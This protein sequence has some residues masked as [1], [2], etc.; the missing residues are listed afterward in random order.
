MKVLVTGAHGF[1]GSHVCEHLLAQG[2][3]VR[4]LVS[5]WGEVTNL[6]AVLAHPHFELTRADIT[7]S[8]SLQGICKGCDA[9]LHA[10][11]RVAD[12]GQW[13]QFEQVNV[14][15]T[16]NLLR[17]A[18]AS[19]VERFVLVSS[20]A[21][22]R[23]TGFRNADPSEVPRNNTEQ[24]YGRSKILAE[25]AVLNSPVDGLIVRPG[26]WPFGPR[27]PN[28]LRVVQVL[29]RGLLPLVGE[30][31]MVINTAYVG[32][33]VRG[34]ELALKV[35]ETKL[36]RRAYVIADEGT[37]TWLELFGTLA[38]LLNVAPPR[39]HLPPKLVV[40]LAKLVENGYAKVAPGLEPPLTTYRAKLMTNDV[41][42]SL[43]AAKDD[44]GY[45]PE[46]SWRAG[47]VETLKAIEHRK[48]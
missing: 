11:A 37:P 41:H 34:L 43:Q 42:F 46:L 9:V 3:Q 1:I 31:E 20:V 5:P 10:A 13:E 26:L 27:D 17:E 21:V 39:L 8:T 23:Y 24:A 19:G 25:D 45:A 4:A 18:E 14:H 12:W 35:S 7:N 28:F 33:L 16:E 36:T 32:N 40:P 6:A 29:K 15:G 38:E 44:L 2:Y 47:L 22:H 30:G 48:S